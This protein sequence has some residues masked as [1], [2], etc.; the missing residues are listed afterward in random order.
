[1]TT[2]MN[3]RAVVGRRVM[4]TRYSDLGKPDAAKPGIITE[5]IPTQGASVRIRL[6]GQRYTLHARPDYQGL[7]YLDEVTDVPALPMGAFTP[8]ADDLGGAWEGVPVCLLEDVAGGEHVIA[9]TGD[10]AAARTAV[11]TYLTETGWDVEFVD[12]DR[13][14]ARWAVFEWEPEDADSP[15]TVNLDASEDDDQA[16]HIYYLPA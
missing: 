9:L 16:V 8:T 4:F 5:L 1:M 6:D 10:T 11:A 2:T 3:A 12:L 7:T 14:E 15:W 13:L